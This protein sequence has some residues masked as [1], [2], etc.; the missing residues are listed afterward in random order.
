[1][2]RRLVVIIVSMFLFFT[3][4]FAI[5]GWGQPSKSEV[6]EYIETFVSVG[7]YAVPY[8]E[9]LSTVLSSPAIARWGLHTWVNARLIKAWADYDDA[10]DRR[11]N[12][13]EIKRLLDRANRLQAIQTCIA[14]RDCSRLRRIEARD[15]TN[16]AYESNSY[17]SGTS[18]ATATAT[19]ELD[20]VL[21][22]EWTCTELGFTATC[23]RQ[24]SSGAFVC[25]WDG[26]CE[27]SLFRVMS[28][29]DGSISMNRT[30]Q[31]C[32]FS[33][34]LTAKYKGELKGRVIKG[35]RMIVNVGTGLVKPTALLDLWQNFSCTINW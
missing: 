19:A 11:T 21:G 28:S 23:T 14:T 25:N 31:K 20:R 18:S 32:T 1:M 17:D 12:Q 27:D 10:L 33:K 7:L 8:S 4:T 6:K 16:N 5:A 9:P 3:N 26:G 29:S 35:E 13:E 2:K 24:G 34:G 22:N 15:N 30:D